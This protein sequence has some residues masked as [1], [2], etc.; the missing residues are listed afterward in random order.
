MLAVLNFNPV[1]ERFDCNGTSLG[2]LTPEEA[3]ET[4][5]YFVRG[6]CEGP[7]GQRKCPDRCNRFK[8]LIVIGSPVENFRLADALT[9]EAALT[10]LRPEMFARIKDELGRRRA[11][12]MSYDLLLRYETT[13]LRMGELLY[14]PLWDHWYE[15]GATGPKRERRLKTYPENR[16]K[17]ALKSPKF[18]A[19][20]GREPYRLEE[21]VSRIIRNDTDIE[22]TAWFF[23]QEH[24]T[25]VP[26]VPIQDRF[27]A[28]LRPGPTATCGI[29][30][31]DGI[32][33]K[34]D[35]CIAI[36]YL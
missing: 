26:K 13:D 15:K 18:L 12:Q 8:H 35:D 10:D 34:D 19:V 5:W 1:I 3:R 2:S 33:L 31:K 30:D 28:A 14:N 32:A 11:R 22:Q 4:L 9:T 29:S 27:R 17:L 20:M 16:G 36:T 24:E 21:A 6:E 23:V 25:G 7:D